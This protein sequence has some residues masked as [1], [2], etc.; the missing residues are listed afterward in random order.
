MSLALSLAFLLLLP[1]HA[2]P[3]CKDQPCFNL[4]SILTA[5]V[6]DFREFRSST[7]PGPNVSVQGTNVPCQMTTWANNVPM[8]IC[9]A[10][11]PA[12]NA[13]SWYAATLSSLR[14][15]QPSW[16]LDI[17]SPAADHYVDAGPAGCGIPPTE[18]PYLDQCPLHLQSAKQ[19]DG[20]AKLYLWMSS[21]SSPYL[22]SRPPGPPPKSAPSA[23]ITNG[24]DDLCQGLK[25]AFETRTSSF[26]GIRAAKSA[27][28]TSEA[29][30]KLTGAGNC[31]VTLAAKVHST[32][33]GTQY[34]CYWTEAT[35]SAADTRFRDL[36]ARLQVL[37]PSTWS[38]R[39][40]DQL[41]ELAGAKVTAWFAVAPDAKQEVSLYLLNQSVGLHFKTWK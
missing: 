23:A 3:Q 39:Q 35:A 15:I 41:D 21:L 29:V 6:T 30:L 25:K 9:Y 17:S 16:H 10:Q 13:E 24:C 33:A 8:Y 26:E 38:V 2:L 27:G 1:I 36:A 11:V 28:D 18:G 37:V 40:E 20:T 12:A 32:D 31:S 34:I 19:P 5:A 22:V 7:S 14:T 4:Q